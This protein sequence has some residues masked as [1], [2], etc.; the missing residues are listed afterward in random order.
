MLALYSRSLSFDFN[1]RYGFFVFV[2]LQLSATLIYFLN[3]EIEIQSEF[4]NVYFLMMMIRNLL[5]FFDK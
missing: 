2:L 3:F 1:F 5:F 4:L